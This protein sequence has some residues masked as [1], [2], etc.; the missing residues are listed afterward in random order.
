MR[1][2]F[3]IFGHLYLALGP[4]PLTHSFESKFSCKLG[5]NP[6]LKSPGLTCEHICSQNYGLKKQFLANIKRFQKMHVFP[7][8]GKLWPGI[9]RQQIELESCSNPVMTGGVV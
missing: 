6:R 1:A 2:C 7:F 3:Q 4:N 9:T 8:P 5:Q